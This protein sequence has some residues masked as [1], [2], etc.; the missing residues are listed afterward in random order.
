VQK[1]RFGAAPREPLKVLGE[2]PVT[3]QPIKLFEG[4]YGQYVTDGV[5]NASL[6]KGT[7]LDEATLELALPLLEARAAAGPPSKK[8]PMKKK[9]AAASAKKKPAKKKAKAVEE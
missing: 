5:T 3:K 4:R 6:P 9:A 8:R 1:G 7:T 2:S